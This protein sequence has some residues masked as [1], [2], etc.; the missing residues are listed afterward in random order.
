M[1]KTGNR[2]VGRALA[3]LGLVILTGS[4]NAGS[5][6]RGC[7]ARDIQVLSLVEE[8]ESTG[9]ISSQGST[10]AILT[11]LHARMVCFEGRVLDALAIYD[12]VSNSITP[13]A[14][15]SGR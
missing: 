9:A 10:V 6:T 11:I 5:F 4:A 2:C 15:L 8:R 1:R 12:D 14:V 3:A 13:T 7:A